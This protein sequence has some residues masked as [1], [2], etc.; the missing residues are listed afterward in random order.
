M[1]ELQKL[2]VGNTSGPFLS[3][4][5]PLLG[6]VLLSPFTGVRKGQRGWGYGVPGLGRVAATSGA[7]GGGPAP[8][9]H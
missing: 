9:L 3:T 4:R 6:G 2:A 8:D 1:A 5:L 7:A